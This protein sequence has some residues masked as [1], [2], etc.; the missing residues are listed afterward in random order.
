MADKKTILIAQA[1]ISL[2]MAFLM[3]G[4]F[5]LIEF[6]PTLAWLRTWMQNFVTA[7]PIAFVLSIIVSK[8]SFGIA[9]RI[10]RRR[11][12]AA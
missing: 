8:V 10:T 11:R 2:T 1:L 3:T 6:G 9:F 7:W 5:S 4:I 12:Q